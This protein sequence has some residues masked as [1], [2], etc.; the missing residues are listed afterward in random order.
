MQYA[1]VMVRLEDRQAVEVVRLSYFRYQAQADGTLD[2]RSY[3]EMMAT[4]G[5]AAFGGSSLKKAP[6]G[7]VNAEYR[8]AQRRL[9]HLSR[10][11]PTKD[12]VE[13]LRGLVNRRA[14]RELL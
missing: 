11:I 9:D 12:E 14:R 10:W 2:R 7:V 13:I 1:E 5:E 8:F 6:P 4:A 3:M